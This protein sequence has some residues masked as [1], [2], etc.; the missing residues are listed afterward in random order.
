MGLV[1]IKTVTLTEKGQIAL[2]KE[3]RQRK[4]FKTGSKLA[5]LAFENHIE[6]RPL[7]GID[8]KTV[9]SSKGENIQIDWTKCQPRVWH[10]M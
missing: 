8:E 1:G 2:P 7:E 3:L 5:V 10:K 9:S 4:G 6:L